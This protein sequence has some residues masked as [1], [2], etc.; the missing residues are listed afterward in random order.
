M[1]KW[2]EVSDSDA[3][4]DPDIRIF[5]VLIGLGIIAGIIVGI[6][7]GALLLCIFSGVLL[8]FSLATIIDQGRRSV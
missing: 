2:Q 6:V 1:P 5:G 7:A 3:R 8:G 4:I